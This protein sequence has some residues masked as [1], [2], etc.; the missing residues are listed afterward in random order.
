MSLDLTTQA[1]TALGEL[2]EA[3]AASYL[4]STSTTST[5]TAIPSNSSAN[6]QYIEY[7][8]DTYSGNHYIE[9]KLNVS[10]LAGTGNGNLNIVFSDALGATYTWAGLVLSA[11][12]TANYLLSTTS[13]ITGTGTYRAGA[14]THSLATDYYY[15]TGV[16]SALGQYGG[17][18]AQTFTDSGL[19][20][21]KD[22]VA[23]ARL[24]AQNYRYITPVRGENDAVTKNFTGTN[25]DINLTTTII[26]E[27]IDL[28]VGSEVDASSR[29]LRVA[30]CTIVTGLNQ[31]TNQN[32][33]TYTALDLGVN[34][35]GDYTLSGVFCLKEYPAGATVVKLF[36]ILSLTNAAAD[37]LVANV[38]QGI[39]GAWDSA[40]TCQTY[41]QEN[42][43]G[44]PA[45]SSVGPVLTVGRPY[46]FVLARSGTTITLKIYNDLV[47]TDFV[48]VSQ[49]GST[50][51]WTGR[52]TTAYQYLMPV[53][54]R[55]TG[56][57]SRSASFTIGGIKIRTPPTVTL[58]YTERPDIVAIQATLAKA[59]TLG[60]TEG[61][62][63][64]SIAANL[65]FSPEITLA[66]TEDPDVVAIS[67][68]QNSRVTLSYTERS[69]VV[70]IYAEVQA[71]FEVFS[72]E[73]GTGNTGLACTLEIRRQIDKKWRNFTT[74][75][76]E[77]T[78][79]TLAMT[80]SN[81]SLLYE[82]TI[83]TSTFNGK[84]LFIITCAAATAG[85]PQSYE[86]HYNTGVVTTGG[87][88]FSDVQTLATLNQLVRDNPVATRGE[89]DAN[90]AR[91]AALPSAAENAIAV[92][93]K[94]LPL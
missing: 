33:A 39:V 84:Y 25:G 30:N 16:L 26:T 86:A 58:S 12:G 92:W 37:A 88:S 76:F 2:H 10:A 14:I 79:T 83:D 57:I 93:N 60:Y 41:L 19:T 61:P 18:F 80:E 4:S 21:L 5:F 55:I 6:Y 22:S 67:L 85:K 59:V 35:F 1:G 31:A 68:A 87:L 51:T 91:L 62:D 27:E 7:A 3:D 65:L 90:S 94:T 74:E 15:R 13:I 32:A 47:L 56:T 66:Y 50:L 78:G 63:E 49:V 42:I 53:A 45:Y 8:A 43:G 64:V 17:S 38:L 44:T 20:T 52:A 75:T 24:G 36:N 34:Y 71:I 69:D 70:T 29:I 46:S 23:M 89:L 9:G 73:A 54:S 48:G 28:T 40:T 72:W 77:T 82:V 81:R 11:N